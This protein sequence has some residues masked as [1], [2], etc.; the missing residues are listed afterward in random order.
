MISLNNLVYILWFGII[1][2]LVA[3]LIYVCFGGKSNSEED[4][5]EDELEVSFENAAIIVSES[6]EDFPK[7]DYKRLE[8]LFKKAT[9]RAFNEKNVD[10]FPVIVDRDA[11]SEYV[12]IVNAIFSDDIFFHSRTGN[13]DKVSELL[14]KDSSLVQKCDNEGLTILHWACDRADLSLV[15]TILSYEPDI[16]KVDYYGL[17]PITYAIYSGNKDLVDL[18]ML[19]GANTDLVSIEV[20]EDVKPEILEMLS[21]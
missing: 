8:A 18:L 11:A 6:T 1:P 16:D 20:E 2:I 4:F 12:S 17:V 7:E 10:E 15:R 21:R 5:D 9:A 19:N 14:E 13:L 3:I